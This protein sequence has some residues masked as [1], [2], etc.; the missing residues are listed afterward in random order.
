MKTARLLATPEQIAEEE[1][2]EQLRAAQAAENREARLRAAEAEKPAAVPAEPPPTAVPAAD[3]RSVA[4][5]VIGVVAVVYA[6]HWAQAFFVSLL[7]GIL[8]A[9]ALNPVV[10][11]MQGLRMPRWA[12]SMLVMLVLCGAT[13]LAAGALGGQ[14]R[15]VL[16]QLPE[17]ARKV[18]AQIAGMRD[19]QPGTL[20]KV[21]AAAREIEK[22]TNQ[23]TGAPPAPKQVAAV[24]VEPPGFR[25]SSFLWANSLAVLSFAGHAVIVLFLAFFLLLSGDTFKRKLVRLAGPSLQSRRITVQVLE[26]INA[27]IQD[28]MFM[29]LATNTLVAALSWVAFRVI[30]LENAGAWALAAGLL[31]V[32]PYAGS[33][34]LA[35][36][37]GVSAFLQFGSWA[38]VLVTVG[39]ALAI[40]SIVGMMVATWMT[41]K[42]ARMNPAAVF[43]ALLFWGWLWGIWGLLLAIPI[44]VT[45]K[46]AAELIEQLHPVAE[47]LR[48]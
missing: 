36:A 3:A 26:D 14:I 13:V 16:E 48:A 37:L 40:A 22:A 28:F 41:G 6:L 10:V 39:S 2:A 20:Q 25:L 46:V 33:A 43:V 42:L 23:A 15:A 12:A 4:I 18:S 38:M 32:I 24:V 30:G 31:H 17:A 34:V 35:A 19:G 11:R 8:I 47:M 44:I 5:V 21:Q 7:L 45:V 1:R 29:L 27:S 9:Y